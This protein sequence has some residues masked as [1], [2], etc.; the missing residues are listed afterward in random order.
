MEVATYINEELENERFYKNIDISLEELRKARELGKVLS[1]SVGIAFCE[2]A[3]EKDIYE[4]I[5]N[6]D[7]ALYKVK[8]SN[9]NG[10]SIYSKKDKM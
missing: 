6:A 10:Y 8:K 4:S 2:C 1:S 5:K 9:K 3:K 7:I